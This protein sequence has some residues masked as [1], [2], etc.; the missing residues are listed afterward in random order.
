MITRKILVTSH[1]NTKKKQK[2][3]C[4]AESTFDFSAR[5]G[6]TTKILP[7][8]DGSTSWFKRRGVDRRRVG[9]YSA[10]RNKR[11]PALKNRL[12]GDAEMHKG[13]L[14]REALRTTNGVK[15]FRNTLRPYSIKGCSS[16]DSVSS[17]EQDEEVRRWS[18]GSAGF[19][20]L[21]SA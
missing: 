11:G 13:L 21:C 14:I 15:Y 4:R 18:G 7:L 20:C 9:P 19:H 1:Q 3:H 12:V 5:S 2:N 8:F 16:G 10:R 6:I 17:T